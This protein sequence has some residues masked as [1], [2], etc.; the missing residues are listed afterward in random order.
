MKS[1]NKYSAFVLSACLVI[2]ACT[3]TQPFDFVLPLEID[4]TFVINDQDGSWS[5]S[6]IITYDDVA[7]ALD[8][9]EDDIDFQSISIEGVSLIIKNQDPAL[10]GV[11]NVNL[12]LIDPF[13]QSFSIYL[14]EAI[15]I[16]AG[17][18]RTEVVVT[19][20]A[21]E[22][23]EA[24]KDLLES[25]AL[26]EAFDPFTLVST[27]NSTPANTPLNMD[28]TVVLHMSFNYSQ[29]LDVPYFLGNQ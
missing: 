12:T 23:V 27:G 19:G 24:L 18:Q 17:Q 7:D 11:E 9:L 21:R 8:D 16:P 15:S 13:N 1:L 22:G 14:G 3:E 5:E 2:A 10:T 4:P 28:L 6:E 26:N 29:E 25:Y 20:L